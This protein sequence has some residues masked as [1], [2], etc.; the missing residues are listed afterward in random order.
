MTSESELQHAEQ[1]VSEYGRLLSSVEPSIYGLPQS[2]LPCDKERIKQSIQTLLLC[3]DE[4]N[5]QIREG[6]V[7]GYVF[8]AQ[9]IPDEQ[10]EIAAQGKNMIDAENKTPE[11]LEYANQA[12]RTLSEI[13]AE[14][15]NLMNDI[16]MFIS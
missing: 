4:E 6:L 12:I 1:V 5:E 2:L 7:Q 9:F 11:Q 8:L 16:R 3:L 13:K 15:E 10:A 14:M